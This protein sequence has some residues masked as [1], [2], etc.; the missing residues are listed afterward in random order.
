MVYNL[1]ENIMIRNMK[2][3]AWYVLKHGTW[4]KYST[5]YCLQ[6]ILSDISRKAGQYFRVGSTTQAMLGCTSVFFSTF[7]IGTFNSL[8]ETNFENVDVIYKAYPS[9]LQQD[10]ICPCSRM[11]GGYSHLL[12]VFGNRQLMVGTTNQ[13][14]GCKTTEGM[15]WVL[16]AIS[17]I[18]FDTDGSELKTSDHAKAF[19]Q[20]NEDL[21]QNLSYHSMA[22]K[23]RK[24]NGGRVANGDVFLKSVTDVHNFLRIEMNQQP[25]SLC[26]EVD[27]NTMEESAL[28]AKERR[29]FLD[30]MGS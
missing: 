7:L 3:P 15:L 20:T 22:W 9:G 25:L 11:I 21:L 4:N 16:C 13:E 19:F 10:E 12:L 24:E 1:P 6:T 23:R 8:H 28:R 2:N 26:D 29:H 5:L 27:D 30:F 18:I 17:K 14:K